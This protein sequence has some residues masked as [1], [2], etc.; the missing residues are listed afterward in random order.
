MIIPD[1]PRL[2]TKPSELSPLYLQMSHID[3]DPA[4]SGA[5]KT[6]CLTAQESGGLCGYAISC[7]SDRGI[8]FAVSR[9]IR[10]NVCHGKSS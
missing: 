1:F 3:I 6:L 2:Q 4:Q 5:N 7:L 8:P 9:A 10:E